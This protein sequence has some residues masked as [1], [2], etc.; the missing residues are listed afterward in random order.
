VN[1]L[2]HGM[3]VQ[4]GNDACVALAEA[5]AGSEENFAQLMNKEAARLGLKNTHFENATGL[6]H[7]SHLT[8]VRDLSVLA[9][10]SFATFLSST[11]SIPSRNTP[12]TRSS[13]PTATA[14]SSSTRPSTASRPATPT[15]P[16]TA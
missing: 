1:E 11:R 14:C 4:S 8:T 12:T 5:I 9:T 6:P 7:P 10:A 3:I 15:A 2:L 16:A 13:S